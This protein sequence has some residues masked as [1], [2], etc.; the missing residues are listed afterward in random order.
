M[1]TVQNYTQNHRESMILHAKFNQW[2]SEKLKI[3]INNMSGYAYPYN[4]TMLIKSNKNQTLS[5]K[6]Q[7]NVKMHPVSIQNTIITV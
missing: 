7:K 1:V 3:Y 2:K 4:G 6:I 5:I